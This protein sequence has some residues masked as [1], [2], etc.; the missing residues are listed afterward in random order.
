VQR[1]Q[2]PALWEFLLRYLSSRVPFFFRFCKCG[3]CTSADGEETSGGE[4]L[5]GVLRVEDFACAMRM[6]RQPGLVYDHRYVGI[7]RGQIII[8]QE[9]PIE[10]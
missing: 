4:S 2:F 7:Q 3:G 1:E 5:M 8:A 10:G 9:E 6:S